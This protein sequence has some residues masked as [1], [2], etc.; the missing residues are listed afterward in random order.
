MWFEADEIEAHCPHFRELLTVTPMKGF[1][2]SPDP[3]PIEQWTENKERIGVPVDFGLSLDDNP[4]QALSKGKALKCPK[5]PDPSHPSAPAGQSAF[6]KDMIDAMWEYY[7]VLA[8]APTGSGKTVGI[9]NAVAEFGRTT[10]VV[11]PSKTLMYQWAE[12]A[13]KHLGLTD[14]QIG[15]IGDGKE[16]LDRPFTICVLHNLFLKIYPPDFYQRF[17]MV[18]YDECHGLGAREFSK[19]MSQ[20]PALYRIGVSATPDRKDGCAELFTNFFGQVRVKSAQKPLPLIYK[21]V[22][23]QVKGTP[24]CLEYTKSNVKPLLWLSD[25]ED[26]NNLIVEQTVAGYHASHVV[27]V[28]TKFTRH[29]E[30]LMDMCAKQGI[31]RNQMGLFVGKRTYDTPEGPKE[32]TVK[33]AEL[34]SVKE[35]ATV[36]FATYSMIKEGVDIPRISYGVEALPISDVRQVVGRARRVYKGKDRAYWVSIKDTGIRPRSVFAFLYN[37]T[38]ARIKSLHVVGGVT[39]Q[40]TTQAKAANR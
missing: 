34:D 13:K 29:A 37:F 18:A 36:I 17:G 10:L 15:F 16:H 1:E 33:K 3:E 30:N 14:N 7:T 12:E 22:P 4:I 40:D 8:E 11:V 26:R 6:F 39:I 24:R 31:P 20:F 28:V 2:G 23:F 21:L 27:L 35:N 9:L 32:K 19:T 38:A 25:N 5:R